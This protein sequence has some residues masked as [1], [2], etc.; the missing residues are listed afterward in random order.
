ALKRYDFMNAT[1]YLETVFQAYKNQEIFEKG[2]TEEQAAINAVSRMKGTVDPIFGVNEEYNPF[3][4][5]VDELFDLARGRVNPNANL[6]WDDNWLDEVTAT[7]PF[8][9]EY[10]FDATGGTDVLTA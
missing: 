3:D 6:K 4:V 5:P 9:Q 7:T 10:Q 8:R 1:E 2:M